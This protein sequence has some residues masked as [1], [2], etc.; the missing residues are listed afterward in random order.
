VLNVYRALEEETGVFKFGQDVYDWPTILDTS[1]SSAYFHGSYV[2]ALLAAPP[3][4]W[5]TIV[6]DNTSSGRRKIG[7]GCIFL[8]HFLSSILGSNA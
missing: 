3:E 7:T 1:T 2:H 5:V 8:F 6:W 4:N